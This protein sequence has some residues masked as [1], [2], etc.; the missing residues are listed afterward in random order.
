MYWHVDRVPSSDIAI[1]FTLIDDDSVMPLAQLR[2][3]TPTQAGVQSIRLADHGVRLMPG[4]EYEW[5][6]ALIV[7]PTQRSQDIITN[8]FIRR[9]NSNANGI[10]EFAENGL[11]YDALAE[12]SDE[13]D[14]RPDAPRLHEVRRAL[15]SQAG[16]SDL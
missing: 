11:W 14:A 6:V 16:L 5:S 3:S 1:E 10:V 2:L 9:V 15:L 8:G 12:I 7:D 13:I 4:V